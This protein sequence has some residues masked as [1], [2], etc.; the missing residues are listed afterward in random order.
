MG[1]N[2][3]SLAHRWALVVFPMPGDPVI[4]TARKTF[5]PSLPGFLKLDFRLDG[6]RTHRQG[7]KDGFEQDTTYQSCS[8]RC[9]FST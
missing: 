3:S 5:I 8:H 2:P 7:V 9:N 6:L 1:V 4:S